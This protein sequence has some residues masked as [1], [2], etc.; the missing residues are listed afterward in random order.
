M[1]KGLDSSVENLSFGALHRCG[2]ASVLAIRGHIC[3]HRASRQQQK[4]RNRNSYAHRSTPCHERTWPD[5]KPC[6]R[7]TQSLSTPDC[8][9]A[10]FDRQWQSFP[11]R[12]FRVGR[13]PSRI[14]R[15]RPKPVGHDTMR[16][17]G[18]RTL[19]LPGEAFWL[20][21][22]AFPT[23]LV[24]PIREEEVKC[25]QRANGSKTDRPTLGAC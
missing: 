18:K 11:R 24:E 14:G 25:P 20:R 19:K 3:R 9:S 4:K 16:T 8:R 13:T 2:S 6:K 22:K 15:R 5:A 23:V 21:R 12:R 17:A 1:N 10:G 7:R